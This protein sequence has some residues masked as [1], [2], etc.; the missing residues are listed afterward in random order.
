MGW[1]YRVIRTFHEGTSEASYD[2]CECHYDN[3]G[4][5]IPTSWSDPI[6]ASSDTRTGLLWVLAVMTEGVG[7]PILERQGDKLVEVEPVQELSDDLRKAIG[8]N[9]EYAEGMAQLRR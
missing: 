8:A 2:I 4:D 6:P 7:R 1:N 5:A 9:K 3:K